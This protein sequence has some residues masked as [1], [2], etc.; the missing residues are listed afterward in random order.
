MGLFQWKNEISK[1]K[2]LKKEHTFLKKLSSCRTLSFEVDKKYMFIV[3][4]VLSN[5][6]KLDTIS[7]H[8][9]ERAGEQ[10]QIFKKK[11]AFFIAG[12]DLLGGGMSIWS[13]VH[14]I[15]ITAGAALDRNTRK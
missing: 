11:F 2:Q 9:S 1:S 10:V 12:L 14:I 5:N 13:I 6:I 15:F 3:L 8:P 7:A 4:K